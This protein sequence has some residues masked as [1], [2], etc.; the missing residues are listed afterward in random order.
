[1][2][3]IQGRPEFIN[4]LRIFGWGNNLQVD[5]HNFLD[6]CR[7]SRIATIFVED[8][9]I[10]SLKTSSGTV[11]SFEWFISKPPTELFPDELIYIMDFQKYDL[12]FLTKIKKDKLTKAIHGTYCKKLN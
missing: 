7:F 10:Y 1:M 3:K 9:T 5:W 12:D 6:Y 11:E 8:M 4:Q 2:I